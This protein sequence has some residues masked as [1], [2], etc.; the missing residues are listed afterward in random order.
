MRKPKHADITHVLKAAVSDTHSPELPAT[1]AT[2]VRR[3]PFVPRVESAL[4]TAFFILL[5]LF[6]LVFVVR[7]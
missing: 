5:V 2:P 7:L 4:W 6:L 1:R 3:A